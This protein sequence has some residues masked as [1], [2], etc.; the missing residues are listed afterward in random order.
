MDRPFEE[1][2]AMIYP[3]DADWPDGAIDLLGPAY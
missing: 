1:D 2:W 3:A